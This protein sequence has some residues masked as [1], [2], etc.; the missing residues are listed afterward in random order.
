M[1]I[2]WNAPLSNEVYCLI[3]GFF[4]YFYTDVFFYQWRGKT[5]W[6]RIVLMLGEVIFF[7]ALASWVTLK[8]P[9]LAEYSWITSITATFFAVALPFISIILELLKELMSRIF[10][11]L[12]SL[13]RIQKV[14]IARDSKDEWVRYLLVQLRP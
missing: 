12:W 6:K 1:N 4:I 9:D 3:A 10:G 13:T 7:S 8:Y 11:S 14:L 2:D 5:L